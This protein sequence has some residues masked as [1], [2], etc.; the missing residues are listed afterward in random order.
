MQRLDKPA[1]KEDIQMSFHVNRH[2]GNDVLQ[3]ENLKMSFENRDLFSNINFSLKK[4]DRVG[5]IGSNGVGKTTLFRIILDEMQPT[6]GD[7]RFGTGVD[8]GYYDQ[9][10]NSLIPD[11]NVLGEV[12]DA[13]PSLT[14]T[15]IRN[16][17]ALFLFRGDDVYKP[18][19]QLSGGERGRVMLSKLMLA[20][21]NFLILDEPTNHLDMASK[22]VLEDSLADYPGTMLIIS[23][24]RY[25]LNKIV[26]RILEFEQSGI[27]E[28]L[29]N[30][31]DYLDKKKNQELFATL[32]KEQ[33]PAIT[34]TALKEERRR[35]RQ[36]REKRKAFRQQL[37]EVEGKIQALEEETRKLEKLLYDPDLY[38]D[39]DKMLEI[40]KQYNEKKQ[41]LD[42]V[43]EEWLELQN[44]FEEVSQNK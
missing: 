26:D 15:Q 34:K 23:H 43:Y 29:G 20:G 6:D 31:N 12:W 35:E 1:N 16:T 30:Y 44:S 2:S 8:I 27:T 7:I 22:E 32:E 14:E 18:I 24:D 19:H 13:F 10:Q 4:G 40:Q 41:S 11:K 25:F 33:P 9:E 38:K 17:L 5:I 37:K 39:S 42:A 3:V 36:E 21:D 28:Y